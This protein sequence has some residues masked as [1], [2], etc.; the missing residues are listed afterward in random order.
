VRTDTVTFCGGWNI[1]TYFDK[2]SNSEEQSMHRRGSA[3]ARR[4]SVLAQ[5]YADEELAT[6]EREKARIG[7]LHDSFLREIR[8]EDFW[9]S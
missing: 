4:R 9:W 6:T 2:R 3:E 8:G 1:L 7:Y 5:M